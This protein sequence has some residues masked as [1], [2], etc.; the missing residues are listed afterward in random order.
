LLSNAIK[1]TEEG[2]ITVTAQK[3]ENNKEILVSI[4]DIG[5]GIDSE[6][7]QGCLQNLLQKQT[8]GQI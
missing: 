5:S 2:A 8:K 6:I 3:N 4:K 7:L 1:L